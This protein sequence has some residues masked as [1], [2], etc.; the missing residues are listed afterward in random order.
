MI[1]KSWEQL[2]GSSKDI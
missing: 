1:F 2:S